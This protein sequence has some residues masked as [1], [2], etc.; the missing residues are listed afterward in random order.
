LLLVKRLFAVTLDSRLF[1]GVFF[2]AQ[3]SGEVWNVPF[4]NGF[5]VVYQAT[6]RLGIERK[7]I[8]A[9]EFFQRAVGLRRVSPA[10]REHHRP[11]RGGENIAGRGRGGR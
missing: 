4:F 2:I 7:P 5:D 1:P 8:G 11:M 3:I 6:F 9:A 10:G